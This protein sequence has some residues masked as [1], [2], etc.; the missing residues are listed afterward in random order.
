M[1]RREFIGLTGAT[2]LSI[3]RWGFAQTKTN[4]PMVGFLR[5]LKPDNPIVKEGTIALRKG[6]Q[7]EG[8]I[9]GTN[10]FLAERFAEGD[11]SRIPQF[12]RELGALN[13]R[14]IVTN[15][16]LNGFGR[17]KQRVSS[18]FSRAATCFLQHCRRRCR[19]RLSPKL[20]APGRDA[21]RK[22][23]ERSRWRRNGGPKAHRAF[24]G[25]CP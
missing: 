17:T 18:S 16:I 12:A 4:M 3:P 23:D 14:V 11:L 21:L 1:K 20:C 8:F 2:A 9:E 22:R 25:A 24:Q 10:Y 19:A 13:A 5:G 7:E 15:G 6:L